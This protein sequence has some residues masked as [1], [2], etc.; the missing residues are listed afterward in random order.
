M[1]I[2]MSHSWLNLFS[3]GW[4]ILGTFCR[5]R[6]WF[7]LGIWPRFDDP[8]FTWKWCLL[9]LFLH[10]NLCSTFPWFGQWWEGLR[11]TGIILLWRGHVP[12]ATDGFKDEVDPPTRSALTATRWTV[13]CS[14]YVLG[15]MVGTLVETRNL[16]SERGWGRQGWSSHEGACSLGHRWLQGRGWSF[17]EEVCLDSHEADSL[18]FSPCARSRGWDIE[19]FIQKKA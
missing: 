12:L 13:R 16:Y 14:A 7:S 6:K 11:E 2:E 9:L 3:C 1:A 8:S 4:V 15:P 19:I 18:L 5:N 10:R 17:Y